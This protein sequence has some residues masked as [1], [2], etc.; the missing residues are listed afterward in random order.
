M[1]K[2]WPSVP[3]ADPCLTPSP[4]PLA[5]VLLWPRLVYTDSEPLPPGTII[6][7]G[8]AMASARAPPSCA[9]GADH[10]PAHAELPHS[11]NGLRC[12]QHEGNTTF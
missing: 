10:T 2:T 1:L 11:L 5:L 9:R 3:W 7:H 8:P 4:L 6:C 12:P